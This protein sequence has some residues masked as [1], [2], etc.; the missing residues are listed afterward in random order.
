MKTR[1]LKECMS[2]CLTLRLAWLLPAVWAPTLPG[3]PLKVTFTQAP[4][5]IEAYDL[6]EVAADVERPDAPNPFTDAALSG[7]FVKAGGTERYEVAGFCDS[8]DGSV[9]RIRFMPSSPGD[10]TYVLTYRQGKIGRAHV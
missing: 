8:A 6:V 1:I 2:R 3:S 5:E 7:T 10:Y 9:F 4:K